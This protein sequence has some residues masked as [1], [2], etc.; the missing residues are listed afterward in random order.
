MEQEELEG[1]WQETMDTV[2]I[3]DSKRER[4]LGSS[5]ARVTGAS[6]CRIATQGESERDEM[7]DMM[8]RMMAQR[9]D[10]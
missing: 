2:K 6:Q 1:K 7:L 3:T 5:E 4:L 9:P 10:L 8:A